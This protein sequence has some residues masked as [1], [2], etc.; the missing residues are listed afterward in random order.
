MNDVLVKVEGVSKKYC[1]NLR[2]SLWHGVIDLGSELLGRR[3]ASHAIL[4]RDEFWAVQDISFEL[5]RGECLGLI[6]RNGSGKTTL[7]R[8]LNGLIRP[9]KGRI[10]MRGRVSALIS[11]GA[12]FNPVLTGRENVYVNG[13]I[14]GLHKH[15]IDQRIDQIIDFS[16]I[17]DFIDA[18]VQTYSS[19]MHVRLGFA[20]ATAIKPEILILDEILA[21]GDASFRKKCYSAIG[22]LKRHCAT[23]IVNHNLSHL[24]QI[25][26]RGIVLGMMQSPPRVQGIREA[27]AQYMSANTKS[28]GTQVFERHPQSA[29]DSAS[30]SPGTTRIKPGERL[31]VVAIVAASRTVGY[32]LRMFV[33][34]VSEE[35]VAEWNTFADQ[36]QACLVCGQNTL[37]FSWN[38]LR[39]SPGN[40]S[41]ELIFYEA[42]GLAISASIFA[43]DSVCVIGDPTGPARIFLGSPIVERSES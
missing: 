42:G 38:D 7:L 15:E 26:D 4:R 41:Y 20:V 14:L 19:G 37:N 27:I 17:G 32:H 28:P 9:D 24:A 29:I 31:E 5:R 36:M 43:S 40:Y 13:S 33:R 16:E 39:L 34:D 10:E 22:N 18:P 6:G 12:G 23:I 25:C 11:L 21:V 35:I 30:L 3:H 8:M 2:Q 1:R